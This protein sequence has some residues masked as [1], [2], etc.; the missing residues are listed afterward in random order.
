MDTSDRTKHSVS[1]TNEYDDASFFNE[2]AKM[3]RSQ[4]GLPA[5]GEWHQFFRLCKENAFL[6]WAAAMAGTASLQKNRA[7]HRDWELT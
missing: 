4:N 7:P 5:A 1:C 2:Y 6:I 3:A